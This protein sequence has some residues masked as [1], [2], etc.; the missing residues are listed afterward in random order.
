[1]FFL[2]V[3]PLEW[4]DARHHLA[5]GSYC[6]VDALKTKGTGRALNSLTVLLCNE[7]HEQKHSVK[8]KLGRKKSKHQQAA[9]TALKELTHSVT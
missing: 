9:K 3:F 6:E 1:M 8:I 4:G 5:M 2:P 7:Y